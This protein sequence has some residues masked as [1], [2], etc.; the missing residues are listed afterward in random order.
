MGKG[1][2]LG[3]SMASCCMLSTFWKQQ[4]SISNWF[5]LIVILII[6]TSVQCSHLCP[7]RQQSKKPQFFHKTLFF[8][9]KVFDVYLRLGLSSLFSRNSHTFFK[10]MLFNCCAFEKSAENILFNYYAVSFVCPFF[11]KAKLLRVIFCKTQ[12]GCDTSP[13]RSLSNL[14]GCKVPMR[15]GKL[16]ISSLID[17][18]VLKL[19]L[20]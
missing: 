7:A 4:T 6:H 2:T 15:Y 3:T 14:V 9:E 1:Q 13:H 11:K 16:Q 17:N 12:A 10:K 18:L 20:F 8:V 5:V 19:Q